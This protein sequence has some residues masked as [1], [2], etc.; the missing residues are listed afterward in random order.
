MIKYKLKTRKMKYKETKS[1]SSK[2]RKMKKGKKGGDSFTQEMAFGLKYQD[3]DDPN[4]GTDLIL[5]SYDSK[6]KLT[7]KRWDCGCANTSTPNGDLNME[8]DC[9]VI[10]N[11]LYNKS[12]GKWDVGE[13]EVRQDDEVMDESKEASDELDYDEEFEYENE[14]EKLDNLKKDLNDLEEE[15]YG[16]C[17]QYGIESSPDCKSVKKQ[18]DAKEREISEMRGGGSKKNRKSKLS[19]L[20]SLIKDYERVIKR[21]S[22]KLLKFKSAS[23]NKSLNKSKKLSI[24]KSK[25]YSKKNKKGGKRY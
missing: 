25:K 15:W 21:Y 22:K 13:R 17:K 7:K 10:S 1:S 6:G 2:S 3:E 24:K 11:G 5:Q 20:K 18:L 4:V 19:K 23:K 14:E 9:D 8:C 16:N 12:Y